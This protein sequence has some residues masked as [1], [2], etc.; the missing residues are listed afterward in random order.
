[1]SNKACNCYQYTA[2]GD[3]IAVGVGATNNYGYVNYFRD[4]LETLYPC[5]DLANKAAVGVT[6][7][8]LLNQLKQDVLTRES[9]KKANVITLSVGGANLFECV[10]NGVLNETCAANGVLAFINDWPQI[11]NEIRNLI[12]SK[13]RIL[14][15]T[16][17][18]PLIGVAPDYNKVENYLQQINHV[19]SSIA[20]RSMYH[21][22]VVDVHEDFQGLFPDGSWK[23]CTWTHICDATPD[24]HPTNSGHIE[25]ARLHD[26]IYC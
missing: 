10:T 3:S 19:I 9:V 23:V 14:V 13:A 18:N 8:K 25:I 1:M 20:Y 24:V 11:M 22:R 17:Y 7:S 16:V 5:V 2:L 4:F 26:V 21:Y 12:G 15:M 6:S